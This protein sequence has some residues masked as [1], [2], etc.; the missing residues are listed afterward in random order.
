MVWETPHFLA[1]VNAPAW[2]RL[3]AL[4]VA[5]RGLWGVVLAWL[6]ARKWGGAE[7]EH[8]RKTMLFRIAGASV[9]TIA[10]ILAIVS[11]DFSALGE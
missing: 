3:P 7:A 1:C 9:L 10:V 2:V 6:V 4:A 5:L 11:E 8:S